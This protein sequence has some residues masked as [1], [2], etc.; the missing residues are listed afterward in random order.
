MEVQG[1]SFHDTYY[2]GQDK[3]LR[4]KLDLFPAGKLFHMKNDLEKWPFDS[5]M[6]IVVSKQVV[7]KVEEYTL[8]QVVG[9][10]YVLLIF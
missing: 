3:L 9:F 2:K 6:H 4:Q 8:A 10:K 7:L 5:W 1:H